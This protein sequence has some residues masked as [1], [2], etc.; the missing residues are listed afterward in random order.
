MENPKPNQTLED[1]IFMNRNRSYGAYSLRRD[2]HD[3]ILK[4]LILGIVIFVLAIVSPLIF[5]EDKGGHKE[6][7][8]DIHMQEYA[9]P[10]EKKIELPKQI[11]LVNQVPPVAVKTQKFN[12]FEITPDDKVEELPPTQDELSKSDAVIGSVNIEAEAGLE[13]V[14]DPDASTAVDKKV[15]IP[16]E[17][18]VVEKPFLHVEIMPEYQGGLTELSRFLQKNLRYPNRAVDAGIGGKVY[19]TFIVGKSGEIYNVEVLKGLG[20][21]CDEE[22]MRVIKLMKRWIPG[23]QSNIP[24]AVKFTLPITFQLN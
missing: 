19:M 17:V 8:V 16:V 5:A 18:E 7:I 11:P 6:T 14:I 12:D 9:I 22:A 2:Y 13:A 1:I 20:F 15:D 10:P 24:V 3:R 21:G 23:K 4:A